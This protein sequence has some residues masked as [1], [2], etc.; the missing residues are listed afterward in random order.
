MMKLSLHLKLGLLKN[1]VPV[2]KPCIS[3]FQNAKLTPYNNN[4]L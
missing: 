1:K 3:I 4:Y 2:E